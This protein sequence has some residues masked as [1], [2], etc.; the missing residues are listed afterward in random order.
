M[1][2]FRPAQPRDRCFVVQS[3]L[4]SYRTAYTAGLISMETWTAVMRPEIERVLDRPAQVIVAH[5]SD[6]PDP[7]AD[8]LGYIAYDATSFRMPYVYYVYVKTNFRRAGYR[9]GVRVGDGLG[10]RLFAAAGINPQQPFSYACSTRK[11][12]ELERKIPLARW[13][14]LLARFT[15]EAAR[16]HSNDEQRW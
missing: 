4:E 7:I 3:W 9:G 12:R 14:P 15:L 8:L 2:S 16:R 13:E 6:D 11:V 1:I 10:R 5:E